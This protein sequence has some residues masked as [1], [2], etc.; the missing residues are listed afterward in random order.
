MDRSG[1][2]TCLIKIKVDLIKY[3]NGLS[4]KKN[5]NYLP[6]SNEKRA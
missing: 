6:S 2:H 1:D 5:A 3:K 4:L